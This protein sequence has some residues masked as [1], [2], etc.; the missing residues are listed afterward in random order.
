MSALSEAL[1]EANVD[2]LSA[3][4]I[5][6]R[7][8]DRVSFSQLAK[9]FKPVHP[10]P[11]EEVLL[12]FSEVLNIPMPKLRSLA[13]QPAGES[14]PYEPPSEANRL[15]GRQRRVVNELIRMLAEAKAGDGDVD[16]DAA[17]IG[18]VDPLPAGASEDELAEAAQIGR[19]MGAVAE[20]PAV[21]AEDADQSSA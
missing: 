19:E 14:T 16:R 6:R 9:Y 11:G 10:R 18:G 20:P 2:Q 12:V 8:G 4:E 5:A 15:D 13:G 7:T 3:R 1:V 17:P 21:P